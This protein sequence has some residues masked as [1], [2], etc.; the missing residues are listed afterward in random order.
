MMLQEAG[1]FANHLKKIEKDI[2]GLKNATEGEGA[3]RAGC[4]HWAAA[5]RTLAGSWAPDSAAPAVCAVAGPDRHTTAVSSA[6]PCISAMCACV[7]PLN[8]HGWAAPGRCGKRHFQL[9]LPCD[10]ELWARPPCP[11]PTGILM[12]TK[13]VLS[14]PLPRVY[15]E[16][17]GG[18]VVPL[19]ASAAGQGSVVLP[20]GG[21]D[22]NA[23]ELAKIS[24][25]TS[26]KLE[27]EVLAPME[28]WM[29]AYA[30]VQVGGA[31]ARLKAECAAGW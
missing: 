18:K 7:G 28:R 29:N 22:F 11:A 8:C 6:S 15:E 1:E 9:L 4:I 27:S 2:R 30:L 19:N 3:G 31:G 20:I 5:N 12:S 21:T 25:E 10:P 26:K 24:K 23:E 17:Q 14:A 13:A 16:T